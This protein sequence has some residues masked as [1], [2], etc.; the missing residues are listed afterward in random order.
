MP[1]SLNLGDGKGGFKSVLPL[2]PP[3]DEL[4]GEVRTIQPI[5]LANRKKAMIVAFNNAPLRLLQ[6]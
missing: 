4:S 2:P 1:L 5:R 6:Y 3:L